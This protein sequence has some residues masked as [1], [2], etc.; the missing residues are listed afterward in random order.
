MQSQ[1]LQSVLWNIQG[2]KTQDVYKPVIF[3]PPRHLI[4]SHSPDSLFYTIMSNQADE[5]IACSSFLCL[6]NN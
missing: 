5:M 3:N 2:S 1:S 6:G 4:E